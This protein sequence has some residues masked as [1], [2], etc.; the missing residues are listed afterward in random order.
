MNKNRFEE[1]FKEADKAFDG[2]YNKELDDLTGLSKK[3][4]DSITPDTTD[5]RVYSV[6]IKVVENASKENLSKAQLVEDIKSLGETAIK[7]AK[8]VPQLAVL[9]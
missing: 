8:K 2:K 5:L 6:L 9:F 1:L 4:V 7:I 3:E